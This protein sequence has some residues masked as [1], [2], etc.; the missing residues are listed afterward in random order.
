MQERLDE[1]RRLATAGKSFKI[2]ARIVDPIEAKEIFPLLNP[3]VIVGGLYNPGDGC[4]DPTSYINAL[5]RSAKKNGG[6]IFEGCPVSGIVIGRTQFGAR[7]VTG[8]KTPFGTINTNC[9]VNCGG[10]KNCHKFKFI[11]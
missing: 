3:E 2:D 11:D 5:V 4:V 8:V 1:Y 6:K 9:V 10:M 7:H